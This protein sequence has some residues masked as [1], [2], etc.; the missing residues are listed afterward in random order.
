MV[1]ENYLVYGHTLKHAADG[2]LVFFFPDYVNEI[3]PPSPGYYLYKCW[4]LTYELQPMEAAH[5]SSRSGR[6][7]RSMS[8]NVAMDMPPTPPYAYHGYAGG[9]APAGEASG[10]TSGYH[11]GWKQTAQQQQA[12]SSAW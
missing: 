5:K 3:P 12:G 10:S 11:P 2:T 6:M 4:S 8:R 7:T 9:Y 1:D